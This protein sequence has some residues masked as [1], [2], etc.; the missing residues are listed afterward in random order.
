MHARIED[1]F[2]DG[3]GGVIKYR[4]GPVLVA[5]FPG[6]DVVRMRARAVADFVLVGNVFA[7]DGRVVIHG[8]VRIHDRL[9]LFV[10]DFDHVHCIGSGI[11]I[12]GDH[13]RNFLHLKTDF[14]VRQHGLRV[15]AD[16]RHPVQRQRP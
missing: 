3:H 9:Q 6:K 13:H 16:R 8:L 7:N 10:L 4:V 15:T 2:P 1:L 14:F 12:A 5:R 11:A